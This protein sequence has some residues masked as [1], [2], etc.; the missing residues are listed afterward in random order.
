[1]DC[2]NN[3]VRKVDNQTGIISTIAGTGIAG[4]AGDCGPAKDALLNW[5]WSIVLDKAGQIYFTELN[6]STVRKI[7]VI[8]SDLISGSEN[9]CLNDSIVLSATEPGGVWTSDNDAVA[10][11]DSNGLVK[12]LTAGTTIIHYTIKLGGCEFI[13][14]NH[15]VSINFGNENAAHASSKNLCTGTTLSLSQPVNGGFWYSNNI[16]VATVDTAGH[17]QC[18][19]TG[20]A[21]L[22]YLL[23]STCI[24]TD[25]ISIQIF[26]PQKI[27]LGNDTSICS[28]TPLTINA[29]NDFIKYN[30]NTNDITQSIT[31]KAAGIYWLNATDVNTCVSSD[32]ITITYKPSPVIDLG[33]DTTLCE[34]TTKLL[35]TKITNATYLWQDGSKNPDYLVNKAGTYYVNATMN[36]CKASDTIN[37]SYIPK[38]LFT[39][40]RDTFICKGMSIVLRPTLN[41]AVQ[42]HWQ[43]GNTFSF[44]DVTDTGKYILTVSNECGTATSSVIISQGV[45]QLYIPTAFSPNND[46]LNDIFRVKYPFVVTKFSMVVYNRFGQKIFETADMSKG[47]DGTFKGSKQPVNAYVWIISLTDID[48]RNKTVK[49]TVMLIK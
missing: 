28:N 14:A 20:T 31:V 34:N 15:T 33:K 10:H 7:A 25:K 17:L 24:I 1:M 46:N 12:G 13:T 39:L 26:K 8:Q 42:Y 22:K 5:P 43:D 47:W 6:N 38:P 21:E 27:F 16:D 11:I 48:G 49:G 45:C 9:I 35:T 37:I 30:W 18:L 44:Y 32:S 23:N 29:G 3:R 19:T 36:S 41:T 2:L 40:G 4:Y